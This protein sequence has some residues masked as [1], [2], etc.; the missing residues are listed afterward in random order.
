MKKQKNSFIRPR[1]AARRKVLQALYHWD[2]NPISISELEA[3]LLHEVSGGWL[4]KVHELPGYIQILS[5]E[6]EEEEIEE[7]EELIPV[8]FEAD[9]FHRMLKGIL[10]KVDSLDES[11]KPHLDRPLAEIDPVERAI[12]RMGAYELHY[13]LENPYRVILNEA[14]ELAKIFGFYEGHKYINGVLDKLALL[15]RAKEIQNN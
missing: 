2:L 14:I 9:Y 6:L 13:A 10:E 15:V 8:T 11:I 3:L 7:L 1:T 4:E 12:L 5:E